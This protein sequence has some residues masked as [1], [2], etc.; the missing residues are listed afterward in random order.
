[1]SFRDLVRRNKIP[2][3]T[4]TLLHKE[5][6]DEMNEIGDLEEEWVEIK[7]LEGMLQRSS[8]ETDQAR[9]SEEIPNYTGYFVPN[10]TIPFDK[11]QDYRIMH[12]KPT[13]TPEIVV[14]AIKEIDRNLTLKGNQNHIKLILGVDRTHGSGS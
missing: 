11:T 9:G 4:L 6:T 14:Y 2:N 13:V 5:Y 12:I 3:E 1:M 8:T 7:V 10:F